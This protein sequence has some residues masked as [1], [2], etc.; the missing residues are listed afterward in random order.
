MWGSVGRKV[1]RPVKDE[2]AGR[3]LKASAKG[4]MTGNFV[5]ITSQN[6]EFCF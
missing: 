2:S 5:M 4:M 6:W 1:L 3:E